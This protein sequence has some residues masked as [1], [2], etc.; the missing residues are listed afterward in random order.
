MDER[1]QELEDRLQATAAIVRCWNNPHVE[2]QVR[3]LLTIGLGRVIVVVDATKEGPDNTTRAYLGNLLL[4]GRVFLIEMQR[5]FT[6]AN[7]LN[8]ALMSIQMANVHW[9]V[10]MPESVFRYVLPI[11]VETHVTRE[12]I[13]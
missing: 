1:L 8:R 2:R 13:E 7:A 4:D 10:R 5:G 9:S 3:N 11:S 12:H 6:W